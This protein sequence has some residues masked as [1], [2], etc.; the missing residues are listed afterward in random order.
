MIE[1]ILLQI[2]SPVREVLWVHAAYHGD[3]LVYAEHVLLHHLI[4]PLLDLIQSPYHGIIVMFVAESLLHMHQQVLH[5][6][7][8]TLIQQASLFAQVPTETGKDVGVHTSL[9]ILLKEDIYIEAPECAHHLC[10]WTGQLKDRH[11][12][13]HGCQLFPLPT[14]SAPSVPMPVASSLTRSGVSIRVWHPPSLGKRRA[15]S[16][17]LL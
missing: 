9:I 2:L 17:C 16:L 11:I 8:F 6:D 3:R 12:Q 10:P 4:I 13:S 15:N 7:I 14:P 1:A 5:R